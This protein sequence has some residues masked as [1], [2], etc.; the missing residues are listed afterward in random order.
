[1]NFPA[2]LAL[3]I[4]LLVNT[5]H[6]VISEKPL[7]E[8]LKEASLDSKSFD[9][10]KQI[11]RNWYYFALK[12]LMGQLAKEMLHNIDSQSGEWL[13]LCLRRI[14]TAKDLKLTA[15]CLTKTK[16]KWER[17]KRENKA[18]LESN[19]TVAF[20]QEPEK[21]RNLI[22]KAKKL[23]FNKL[24]STKFLS[25]RADLMKRKIYKATSLQ[26]RWKRSP[27]RLVEPDLD[28]NLKK[29]AKSGTLPPL[30]AQ[31]TKS[32]LHNVADLFV[33]L[34]GKVPVTDLSK[35]WSTTYKNLEKMANV[36]ESN[37]KLPGAR[38]YHTRVYDIVLENNVTKQ[39]EVL[40]PPYLQSVFDLVNSFKN[41]GNARILSPRIAPL[42]PDKAKRKGFLSPS[43][44]PF[45]KDDTEEQILPIPKLLEETGMSEKDREKVFEMIMEVSGARDA[46][47]NALKILQHLSS[48][49]LGEKILAVSEHVAETFEQLRSSMSGEQNNDLKK[50]GY[51]FLEQAQWK[52]L[53]EDQDLHEPEVKAMVDEYGSLTKE[54]R[55]EALWEAISNIAGLNKRRRHKR[56]FRTLSV[57][58]PTVLSPYQFA[59]VFGLSVLGPVVLSPNTFSPLLLDP[60]VLG[61]WVLSPSVPLPFIISPYLLSPYVLSPLVMAP[62]V[63]SPYVLSPNVINPYVLSPVVL[64]PMV[65]CPDVISPMVLAGSVLSPS[66]ASPSVLSKSYLMADVLSPTVFS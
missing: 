59:P 12:A 4:L 55:E 28:N 20:K 37:E 62:F 45:Y 43:V 11:H 34:F 14:I 56:Q 36:L 53:H 19:E 46:A 57:L 38:V 65:L 5:S 30:F 64:S 21:H 15:M 8:E 1:M 26:R 6:H 63:F 17:Y 27:Y 18:R 22:S 10:V 32:P 35:K 2:S 60:S 58:A 39:S 40:V 44:F 7:S 23:D 51:T 24:N 47:D 49:G 54:Q 13:K 31:T 66:V 52:K 33:S 42:M 3:L 61:P 50:K 48:F 9:K 41:G 25:K 29:V 16:R